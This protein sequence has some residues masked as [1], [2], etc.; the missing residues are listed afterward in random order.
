MEKYTIW[1]VRAEYLRIY[2]A[3]RML[4][5]TAEENLAYVLE[6]RRWRSV[7][8]GSASRSTMVGCRVEARVKHRRICPLYEYKMEKELIRMLWQIG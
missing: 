3:L 8:F 2:L 7:Q 1:K 4:E 5:Y 6:E